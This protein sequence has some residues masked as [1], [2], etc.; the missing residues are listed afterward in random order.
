MFTDYD[1][2]M[3]PFEFSG[4]ERHGVGLLESALAL[5]RQ[6]FDGKYLY[7]TWH[8]KAGVLLRSLIKNHPLVDGNKRIA[9]ATTFVFLLMNGRFLFALNDDMVKFALSVAASEPDTSWRT[10][11][12][13]IRARAHD[14]SSLQRVLARGREI[15]PERAA[16]F[17]EAA[18]SVAAY[19]NWAQDART[20]DRRLRRVCRR[21][22]IDIEEIWAEAARRFS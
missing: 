16:D 9:L 8:D 15:H 19:W 10:V 3:P 11:A 6:T 14:V 18:A 2:P 17:E 21:E 5:P 12:R 1:S 22:G 20:M 4:G 7:R 13:W